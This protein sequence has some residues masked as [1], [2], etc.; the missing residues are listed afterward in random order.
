[1]RKVTLGTVLIN[2]CSVLMPEARR[3]D[4]EIKRMSWEFY[5]ED[6]PPARGAAGRHALAHVLARFTERLPAAARSARR[7]GAGR[8]WRPCLPQRWSTSGTGP[9]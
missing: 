3:R 8:H 1:M 9:S 4:T 5:N 2:P 7:G 6:P